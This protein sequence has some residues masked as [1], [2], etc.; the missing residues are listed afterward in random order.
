MDAASPERSSSWEAMA[1]VPQ[2]PSRGHCCD[3]LFHS[4]DAHIWCSLLLLCHHSRPTANSSL[5]RIPPSQR[6]VDRTAVARNLGIRPAAQVLDLRPGREVFCRCHRDGQT[7]WYRT[8]PN[9]FSKS[10]AER[11][12]RVL[13]RKC[14]SGFA[15]SRGR[16]EPAAPETVA[17]R[18]R[19]LLSR[20]PNSSRIGEEHTRWSTKRR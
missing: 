3:G 16:S 13:G 4:S 7:A 14:A 11:H 17:K 10:L 15:R 20:R 6:L 18:L 19:P 9:R 5:Q 1:A 12:C 8:R 2:K